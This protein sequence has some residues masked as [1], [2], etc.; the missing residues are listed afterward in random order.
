MVK[1]L[2]IVDLLTQFSEEEEFSID[3]E[4]PIVE[5]VGEQWIMKFIGSSIANLRGAEWSFI[6]MMKRLWHSRSS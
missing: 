4:V 6:T 5:L 1:R 3:D 2:A